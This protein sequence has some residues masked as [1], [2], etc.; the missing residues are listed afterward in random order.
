[1]TGIYERT[2]RGLLARLGGE[3]LTIEG[4]GRDALRVRATPNARFDGTLPSGL[5]DGVAKAAEVLAE[6]G[7]A[8]VRHGRCRARVRLVPGGLRPSL[9]LAFE[10][11]ETGAPLLHEEPGHILYPDA[12]HW[13]P[14]AGPLHR[15]EQRFASHD[16][17]RF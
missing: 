14:E 4:A 5:L 8:S 1:M 6:E 12:R 15:L 10:D 16:G 7:D 2:D 11:A 9:R 3:T 13:L 17:E